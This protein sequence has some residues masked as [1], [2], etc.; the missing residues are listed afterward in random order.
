MAIDEH[1]PDSAARAGEDRAGVLTPAMLQ[2]LGSIGK[3]VRFAAVAGY[4]S[5]GLVA[6]MALFILPIAVFSPELGLAHGAALA[7]AYLFGAG[8]YFSLSHS[9]QKYAETIRNLQRTL[10]PSFLEAALAHERSFWRLLGIVTIAG[11]AL[12]VV[13]VLVSFAVI[14][15]G[16]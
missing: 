8:V 2:H 16:R 10:D 7:L 9:L 6:V 3:W 15:S 11:L 12:G 5:A 4:A 13:A 14:L 1:G